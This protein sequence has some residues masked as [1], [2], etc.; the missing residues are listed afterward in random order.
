M[1]DLR[2]YFVAEG[3][4]PRSVFEVFGIFNKGVETGRITHEQAKGILNEGYAAEESPKFYDASAATYKGISLFD[5]GKSICAN[6]AFWATKKVYELG[7]IRN[8]RNIL[9]V[10]CG[11]GL[12]AVFFAG[13]IN[14]STITALD[15]SKPLIKL[16]KVRKKKN[17]AK[18]VKFVVADFNEEHRM[19]PEGNFDLVYS[20]AGFG[21][22]GRVAGHAYTQELIGDFSRIQR[23]LSPGGKIILIGPPMEDKEE[24]LRTTAIMCQALDLAGVNEVHGEIEDVE[25]PDLGMRNNLLVTGIK[26]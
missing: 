8:R 6:S 10:G 11:T 26:R 9:D 2:K 7:D 17:K 21:K 13:K 1:K 3:M 20:I 22:D 23:Y 18:K 5:Y 16:A 15:R 24:T 14:G 12:E 4:V 19:L 25:E